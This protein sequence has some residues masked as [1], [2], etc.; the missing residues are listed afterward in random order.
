MG[1]TPMHLAM[2]NLSDRLTPGE[3][4]DQLAGD[5]LDTTLA[6]LRS[7]VV[8]QSHGNGLDCIGDDTIADAH[9]S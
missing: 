3:D 1:R 6:G 7:G 9:A 2:L 8:L 5:V 4:P